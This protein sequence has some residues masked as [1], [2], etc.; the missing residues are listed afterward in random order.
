[1]KKKK[2]MKEKSSPP[3]GGSD[4][5]NNIQTRAEKHGDFWKRN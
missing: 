2:L 1:M 4:P 5:R 3:T